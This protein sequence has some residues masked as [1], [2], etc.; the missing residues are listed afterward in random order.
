MNNY[1]VVTTKEWHIRS[2]K[3]SISKLVGN[4]TL[5]TEKELF[6]SDEV[7]RRNPKYIFFTHWSWMVDK[8]ITDNYDCVCFHPTDLPYGRGGSPLQNL[9]TLGHKETKISAFR[10]NDEVDGGDIYLKQDLLL[11]GS[12]HEIFKRMADIY[13]EMIDFII[14]SNPEPAP[15]SGEVTAFVRR[16]PEQSRID[17]N[18]S[19]QGNRSKQP[20]LPKPT[21]I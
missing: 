18:M 16:T 9:I 13:V 4:W 15:Q 3:E 21:Q 1:I 12:A 10:M 11:S 6:N 2:Y 5:I 8:E 7:R 20:V 17:E 14:T 19:V